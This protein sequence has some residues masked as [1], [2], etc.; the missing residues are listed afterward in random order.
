MSPPQQQWA[1]QPQ[2]VAASGGNTAR[3]V[4]IAIFVVTGAVVLLSVV[5]PIIFIFVFASEGSSW[6]A[7][8]TAAQPITVGVPLS[9]T[10]GSSVVTIN[11]EPRIDHPLTITTAGQYQIDLVSTD[12]HRY[13][14]V[15]VLLRDGVELG[16]N[17]DGPNGLNSQLVTPMTP[18]SYVVRVSAFGGRPSSNVAY[19][20]TVRQLGFGGAVPPAAGGAGVGA[21]PA[22]SGG[23]GGGCAALEACCNATRGNPQATAVCAQVNTYRSLPGGAGERACT[24]ALQG[25]RNAMQATGVMIPPQC[26]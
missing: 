19:T 17:D 13:D 21:P 20:V 24:T 25:L 9:G 15:V 2:V 12:T 11:G 10:M 7:S 8:G 16:R 23:G 14:P 18:G 1:P 22:V 6:S 26:Q 3:N 4:L 5:A